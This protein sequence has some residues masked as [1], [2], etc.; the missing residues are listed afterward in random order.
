MLTQSDLTAIG[1]LLDNKLNLRLSP[2]EKRLDSLEM[3]MS[4]LEKRMDSLEKRI[5]SLERKV[6]RGFKSVDRKLDTVIDYFDHQ[7]ID[8]RKRVT[9]IE[10]HLHLAPL[11][12]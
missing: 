2:I 9:R 8:L 4:S 3:R 7:D 10:T 5:D 11:N 1:K 6:N 12:S